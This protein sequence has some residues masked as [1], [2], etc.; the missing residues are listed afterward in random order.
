MRDTLSLFRIPQFSV[1]QTM[2]I[3]DPEGLIPNHEHLIGIVAS[4][5]FDNSLVS[6]I[7]QIIVQRSERLGIAQENIETDENKGKVVLRVGK[8]THLKKNYN[9]ILYHEFGHVADRI[10]EKFQY[11]EELKSELSESE[12]SC[13]MELWNVYINS[14]LHAVGLYTPSVSKCIGTLNGIRQ[15]FPGTIEGDL[16]V[17]MATLEREGFSY[18]CA[19]EL[20]EGVWEHPNIP[21]TYTIMI[22]KIK[23]SLANKRLE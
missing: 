17:H 19:K 3:H 23:R 10:N 11:S 5:P 13:V 14:R 12:R 2:K 9:S 4:H 15:T 16:M 18:K 1:R 22:K 6:K 7:S 20:I 21:L 8:S